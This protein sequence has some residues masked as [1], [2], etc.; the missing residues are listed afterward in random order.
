MS[1]CLKSLT[2]LLVL[3][4]IVGSNPAREFGFIHEEAIQRDYGTSEVLLR[5]PLMPGLPPPVKLESCHITFTVLVRRKTQ[6]P[7]C[8]I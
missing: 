7:K 6:P 5:C 3:L 8:Y 4:V 2:H 1:E